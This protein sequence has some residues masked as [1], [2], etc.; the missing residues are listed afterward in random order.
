ML[1]STDHISIMSSKSKKNE[2]LNDLLNATQDLLSDSPRSS[3]FSAKRHLQRSESPVSVI[4]SHQ[5]GH[6]EYNSPIT[7][8]SLQFKTLVLE[9]EN[10]VAM[11]ARH[12]LESWS[13]KSSDMD[14]DSSGIVKEI[15][16]DLGLQ[17][18]Y[19]AS[20]L[21]AVLDSRLSQTWMINQSKSPLSSKVPHTNSLSKQY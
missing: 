4:E 10:D 6:Y 21:G 13:T 12:L 2:T 8:Q 16:N 14:S 3:Y 19:P 15:I 7:S 9:N 20:H 18:G 17:S 11:E 1:S 5:I